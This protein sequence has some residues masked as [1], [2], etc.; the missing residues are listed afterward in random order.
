MNTPS[1]PHM[2]RYSGVRVDP[3]FAALQKETHVKNLMQAAPG[4]AAAMMSDPFL[5]DDFFRVITTEQQLWLTL[6]NSAEIILCYAGGV[7]VEPKNLLAVHMLRGIIGPNRHGYLFTYELPHVR[8]NPY[9]VEVMSH[10]VNYAFNPMPEGLGL[11]KLRADVPVR[12]GVSLAALRGF[13]FQGIG[14]ATADAS[15]H[16][17]LSDIVLLELLNPAI[18]KT[19]EVI[20]NG[21][22]LPDALRDAQPGVIGG[23]PSPA[24]RPAKHDATGGGQPDALSN[25]DAAELLLY[26]DLGAAR[27]RAA[28]GRESNTRAV[29]TDAIEHGA[30]ITD[31]GANDATGFAGNGAT[32]KPV[33]ARRKQPVT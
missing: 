5:L 23:Q 14:V 9:M 7:A 17:N 25:D 16:G 11:I 2:V 3:K 15:H 32:A 21:S 26:S 22:Q 1:E 12:D 10:V 13:G 18:F 27:L 4:V 30:S 28:G 6:L 8:G 20:S 24:Q 19:A 29:S 31:G 33:K